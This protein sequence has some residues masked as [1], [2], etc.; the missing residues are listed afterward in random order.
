MRWLLILIVAGWASW[1]GCWEARRVPGEVLRRDSAIV[2]T[3]TN[4][5]P[6]DAKTVATLASL[7]GLLPAYHVTAKNDPNLE[8]DIFEG[9]EQIGFV[10]INDDA[11]VYNVHATS[12]KV[13]VENHNWRAGQAFQ[14]AKLLTECVCWGDN[15]T[16]FKHGEHVAVNFSRTCIESDDPRALRALDGLIVQRVIWSPAAFGVED[17]SPGSSPNEDDEP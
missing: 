16:C 7:R 1:A 3:P 17:T 8:Y 13:R 10:V 6:I 2:I 14:D 9:N 11:S 5:G 4:F 15:P 12:G